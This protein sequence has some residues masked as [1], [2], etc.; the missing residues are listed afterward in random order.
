MHWG[1][2]AHE[3]LLCDGAYVLCDACFDSAALAGHEHDREAFFDVD[4]D[5][6]GSCSSAAKA[7]SEYDSDN[8]DALLDA[9]FAALLGDSPEPETATNRA[10]ASASTTAGNDCGTTADEAPE[11]DAAAEEQ[12][13]RAVK[14][15]PEEAPV[16]TSV[17]P[18][19]MA[20][21]TDSADA[22][23]MPAS[24]EETAAGTGAEAKAGVDLAVETR[25]EAEVAAA[26]GA[27]ACVK[28][29]Q[30]EAAEMAA[31]EAKGEVVVED[32]AAKKGEVAG[33]EAAEEPA[34]EVAEEVAAEIAEEIAQEGAEKAIGEVEV[35][36]ARGTEVRVAETTATKGAAVE[37][38]PP[39]AVE[40]V[41]EVTAH[42]HAL[43]EAVADAAVPTEKRAE[44]ATVT[45]DKAEAPV[46]TE[47]ADALAKSPLPA[48]TEPPVQ[49]IDD[50][51]DAAT[52]RVEVDSTLV[53][54]GTLPLELAT[55]TALTEGGTEQLPTPSPSNVV[56]ELPSPTPVPPLL[57]PAA[58]A[59]AASSDTS[60]T[61]AVSDR[62]VKKWRDMS[63]EEKAA[64]ARDRREQ[65]EQRQQRK[66]EADARAKEEY[67]EQARAKEE[68][69]R[70]RAS[71]ATRGNSDEDLT[72]DQRLRAAREK[73]EALERAGRE[74]LQ[75]ALRE[76]EARL[77][78]S[79]QERQR[80]L[81]D[82][83]AA[84]RHK[85]DAAQEN[86]LARRL[87]LVSRGGLLWSLCVKRRET[88]G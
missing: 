62:R 37:T 8:D 22:Q 63:A 43:G 53:D 72:V 44:R 45:M 18:A 65:R 4:V 6:D 86:A 20:V 64:R 87:A 61:P 49:S 85:L 69:L 74:R 71:L 7:S 40:A 46:A 68:R 83:I 3:C 48:D 82:R 59:A 21:A 28:V 1:A 70:L 39:A 78:L 38:L 51:Q 55:A 33:V 23:E 54:A 17:L 77:E 32:A 24:T 15:E 57:P 84:H 30:G 67:L 13:R 81:A 5:V 56:A 80:R 14:V 29:A 66:R 60:V 25:P 42:P 27:E 34:K 16:E 9:E 47:A 75:G 50:V 76:T 73:R 41:Q 26:P 2:Q 79:E 35:V 12:S 31:E 36:E 52:G 88:K 58:P 11:P 10:S 19:E